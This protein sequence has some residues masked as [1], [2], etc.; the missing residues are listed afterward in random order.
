MA[1]WP[2]PSFSCF[3]WMALGTCLGGAVWCQQ[4]SEVRLSIRASNG[5]WPFDLLDQ[6]KGPCTGFLGIFGVHKISEK[7]MLNS[8]IMLRYL[9]R[10][11][12]YVRAFA[13]LDLHLKAGAVCYRRCWIPWFGFRGRSFLHWFCLPRRTAGNSAGSRR[14]WSFVRSA[15]TFLLSIQTMLNVAGAVDFY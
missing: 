2:G 14:F 5:P 3:L 12:K 8:W 7:R 1:T 15:Q 4:G 10:N 13:D 9:D 11:Y 6:G